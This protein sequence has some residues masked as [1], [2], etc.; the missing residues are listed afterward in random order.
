MIQDVTRWPV[1]QLEAEGSD[2]KE[3]LAGP[4]ESRWLCKPA[5]TPS[6]GIRQGEDWSEWFAAG[7]AEMF[8]I[9]HAQISLAQRRGSPAALSR[10]LLGP[11]E[12][13][14][15]GASLL[16]DVPGFLP[17]SK[18]RTGHSLTNI[19]R[20]LETVE[21][22]RGWTGPSG[23]HASFG[24]FSG[25]LIFDALIPNTDRHEENWAVIRNLDRVSLA[26]SFDHATSLGFN[27]QDDQ[28]SKWSADQAALNAWACRGRA[29]R[30]E[31]GR[32]TTLVA[33][34]VA[35]ARLAPSWA[36]DRWV[37]ALADL[38][39]N[40]LSGWVD[41]EGPPSMSEAARTFALE[42]VSVNRR[43]LLDEFRTG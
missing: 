38:D 16:Q 35:S 37:G 6:N 8:G 20:A 41:Q 26:G 31:G 22:P 17:R 43:R 39:V 12:E 24:V 7:I 29:I 42:L 23:E 15:S 9:P 2:A 14:Q 28:R 10:F 4:N 30:F 11:G 32:G 21:T 34:A 1:I 25:Y 19:S 3:W 33:H 18:A 36:E 27:L 13:L 40:A 5:V